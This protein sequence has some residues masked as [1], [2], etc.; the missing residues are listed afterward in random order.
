MAQGF[1]LH[2]TW[3][4]EHGRPVIHLYGVLEGGGTFVVRDNTTRPLFYILEDELPAALRVAPVSGRPSSL[5]SPQGRPLREV[6]AA[7]PAR[8]KV[9]REQLESSGISTFEGDISFVTRFLLDRGL[10]GSIEIEGA[11]TAGRR[12]DRIYLN[13]RLQPSDWIPSLTV[14]SLDIETSPDAG[15]VLSVALWGAGV[16]EVLVIDDG[17]LPAVVTVAGEEA[18]VIP[19]SGELAL[20]RG[21]LER[22]RAIDPDVLTGWNV[23]DFDLRV[24][25]EHFDAHHVPFHLGRADLPARL[26]L[27]NAVWGTSRA[28]VPGRVVLDGLSLLR[29]TFVRLEDYRLETAAREV[30]GKG[31][32]IVAAD[33]AAEIMR[34]YHEDRAAFVVYNLTDAALVLEIVESRSLVKLAV[35]LSQVTG[36]PLD[37]T[38]ASIAS[39]DFLY[40]GEMHRRGMAGPTVD[41]GQATAP[42][43]GGFVLASRPGIYD[44]AVVLDYR[45]L[46][47]SLIRTLRLDPLALVAG[48][49]EAAT[50]EAPIRAP[51]GALFRRCGGILPELLDR[52]F[53]L[54][55]AAIASGDTLRATAI[56]ILMNSFYGVLATPRCRFYSPPT[57]NAITG[58]GQET[59]RWTCE[60]V[61]QLGYGVLYGDT[62]SIFVET[63]AAGAA[64]AARLGQELSEKLTRALAERLRQEHGVESRLLLR[65]DRLYHKLLIPALRGST[66]G[67]RKRYAGLVRRGDEEEL[68]FV[69]LE[70]VR[71]DWTDLARTFQREMIAR[72]FRQEPLEE[73]LRGYLAS[74]RRGDFDP[75]LVYRRALRKPEEAYTRT[76]P[77]HVQAAR[78]LSQPGRIVRYVVTTAGPEPEEAREHP[79]DREHYVEKQ[80]RPIAESI[81]SLVGLEWDTVAGGQ[82]RLPF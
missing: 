70:T 80:I 19:C 58:F 63:R 37:R 62:D 47:P 79:I 27:D 49:A 43:Q 68:V 17:R 73:F 61:E 18:R 10:R 35:R 81:L 48:A 78:R 11:W 34:L 9:L 38:G 23:I 16:R 25:L 1:I 65:F 33:R 30:L 21:L 76:T 75:L 3:Y 39:F 50:E 64:E 13:P 36:L 28:Q 72:V 15:E 31:K 44:F 71:R 2:P 14:L 55:E 54:R 24:L 40:L 6:T 7:T 45:S 42:T 8:L 53:P 26:L 67:S 77:P 41:P 46:Y 29:S 59:L 66:E 60:A 51:N 5:R 82:G 12:V 57:A 4:A 20:L 56:K 32:T 74:L 22:L 52:L 69:G